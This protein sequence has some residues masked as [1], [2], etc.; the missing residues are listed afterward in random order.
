MEKIVQIIILMVFGGI[1][2]LPPSLN[3]WGF[4]WGDVDDDDDG[5]G[6]V[7]PSHIPKPHDSL[8][9]SHP[10]TL[11][12]SPATEGSDCISLDLQFS[13]RSRGVRHICLFMDRQTHIVTANELRG[14]LWL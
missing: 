10:L 7:I 12:S 3:K 14:Q 2:A 5:G 4:S 1:T 9:L 13:L 11:S 6:G 8:T